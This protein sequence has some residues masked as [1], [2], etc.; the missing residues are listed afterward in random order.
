MKHIL[1]ILLVA[2]PVITSAQGLVKKMRVLRPKTSVK[3]AYIPP[4]N[5]AAKVSAQVTRAVTAQS[6]KA[7]TA[8]A[9]V[10]PVKPGAAVR[11]A[12]GVAAPSVL[13]NQAPTK[14]QWR[15]PQQAAIIGYRN[16]ILKGYHLPSNYIEGYYVRRIQPYQHNPPYVAGK[17]AETELY[18]G[19]MV[20]PEELAQI[21][22]E[23]FS[24]KT[25][26][27]NIGTTG[28]K[29]A[30]SLSSSFYEASDYIFQS[31]F[32]KEGI[33]VVFTVRRQPY[34]ELGE[35]PVLNSTKT[36]YYS[37][38]DIAPEDI[39]EVDIWGEFGVEKLE[40]V[41]QK[42]Q[43]GTIQTNNAWVNQFNRSFSR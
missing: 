20:T 39:L 22:Q 10:P 3:R 42:A 5:Q 29:N 15:T 31:G 8:V 7:P 35:D 17:N 18:R 32:K 12:A 33:G 36:I 30:V 16:E 23:G 4:T 6:A 28:N 37:Y 27:W 21:M 11:A 26:Q 40:N 1:I 19:M 9:A 34:M 14:I 38:Q 2:C 13:R 25:S 41:L 43:A 24:P